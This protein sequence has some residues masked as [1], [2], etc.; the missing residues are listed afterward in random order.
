MFKGV[1]HDIF[2][3]LVKF[4][5]EDWMATHIILG[6]FEAFEILGQALAKRSHNLTNKNPCIC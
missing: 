6:I 1:L 4:F 3:L 5:R 2:A